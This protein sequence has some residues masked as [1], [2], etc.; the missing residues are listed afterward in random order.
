M[1]SMLFVSFGAALASFGDAMYGNTFPA[2]INGIL[3]AGSLYVFL[4]N[5]PVYLSKNFSIFFFW[6]SVVFLGVDGLGFATHF[7]EDG[8]LAVATFRYLCHT[9]LSLS[10]ARFYLDMYKQAK[11]Q[12]TLG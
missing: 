7:A 5:L 12:E 10:M 6:L 9:I 1:Y 4:N 8:F 2:I 3:A 11:S